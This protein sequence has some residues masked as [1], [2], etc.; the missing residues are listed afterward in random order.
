MLSPMLGPFRAVV[1]P[2]FWAEWRESDRFCGSPP[3]A[4]ELWFGISSPSGWIVAALSNS[5]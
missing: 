1:A 4:P 5:L 3:V 2:T